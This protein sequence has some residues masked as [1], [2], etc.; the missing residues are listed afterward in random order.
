MITTRQKTIVG[1][2]KIKKLKVTTTENHPS[3]QKRAREENKRITK[4]PETNQQNGNKLILI[5]TLY[6]NGI[7]SPIEI[8][9][10]LMDKK[11]NKNK[12]EIYAVYQRHQL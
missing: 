5:N 10:W 7:N 4:H 2:Q 9:R 1:I 3:Q 12:T 6:I 11:Q 8:Y